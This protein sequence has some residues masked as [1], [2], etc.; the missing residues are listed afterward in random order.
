V[1]RFVE[2]VDGVMASA[3]KLAAS[4]CYVVAT[5]ELSVIVRAFLEDW[6]RSR[7]AGD[8]GRIDGGERQRRATFVGAVAWLSAESG[9]TE[10]TIRDVCRGSARRRWTP[11]AEADALVTA[12]GRPDLL[13]GGE[14]RVVERPAGRRAA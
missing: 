3:T 4:D 13:A 8:G 2:D 12:I 11:L 14:L 1:A 9:L 6:G 7:P 10:S 5:D